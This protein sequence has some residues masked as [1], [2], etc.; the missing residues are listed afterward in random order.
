MN[1]DVAVI[2]SGLGGYVCLVAVG[3]KANIENIG[4][5]VI[6]NAIHV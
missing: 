6:G 4:L 1:H 5:D 2:G 3:G